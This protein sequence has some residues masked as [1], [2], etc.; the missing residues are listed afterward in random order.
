MLVC[1]VLQRPFAHV[2]A[3]LQVTN[4]LGWAAQTTLLLKHRPLNS[5]SDQQGEGHGALAVFGAKNQQLP[6]QAIDATTTAVLLG[7]LPPMSEQ[8]CSIMLGSRF[9]AD[10][11]AARRLAPVLK[12]GGRFDHV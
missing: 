1:D 10:A 11:A 7:L 8:L 2:N 5:V 4:A 9:H 6:T 12:E 3:T